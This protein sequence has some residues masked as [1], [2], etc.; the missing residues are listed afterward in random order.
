MEQPL[1]DADLAV[2]L[3][4]M[5]RFKDGLLFLYE[6]MKLYKEVI[7]CY[8]QDHD[9]DGL[10]ACCKKL[11][12]STHGGDPSLWCDLLKYF[13][14]L[15]EDCSKEVKEVLSYIERDDILPPIV[16]LQTLSRN[17]CLALSVVKGYIA[18]KL[19]QETK[20]IENDRK[21]TEK[22]QA[23]ILGT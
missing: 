8:M 16:V 5:N 11:G 6:K 3:C 19:E 10:I 20:L 15:G 21:S 18:R 2:I 14:E 9:H 4:E 22:Y 23:S 13:G 17:P 1:Y 12:D 7:A